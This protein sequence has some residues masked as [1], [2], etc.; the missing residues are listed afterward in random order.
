[1]KRMI[2]TLALAAA[3]LLA[4]ATAAPAG[5][6]TCSA[7]FEGPGPHGVHV[8]DAYVT[9]GDANAAGGAIL[10]GGP[11]AFGHFLAGDPPGSAPVAPGASFCTG[12]QSPGIHLP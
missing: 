5:E 1:M 11:A 12:S 3:M 6:P 7:F 9:G 4:T 2:T 8:R 10:P